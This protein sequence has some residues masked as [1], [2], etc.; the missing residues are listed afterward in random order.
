[1]TMMNKF[2]HCD[3]Y[4]FS[5]ELETAIASA[6]NECSSV[7][8]SD[9]LLNPAAPSVFHSVFDNFDVFLS[10]LEGQSS[11]HS[12]HGIMM[13]EVRSGEEN[14]ELNWSFLQ[15]QGQENRLFRRHR[16][17]CLNVTFLKGKAQITRVLRLLSWVGKKHF[18]K[19]ERLIF[20]KSCAVCSVLSELSR[21]FQLSLDSFRCW[22]TSQIERQQSGTTQSLTNQ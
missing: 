17:N 18:R 8:T 20:S 13:Q 10:T 14:K 16:Q 21:K 2:R 15:C 19:L 22:G 5:L 7:L 9:I 12:A 6:V 1:M 3:S 11:M 4:T